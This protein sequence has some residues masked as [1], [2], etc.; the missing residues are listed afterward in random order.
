[1]PVSKKTSTAA[2]ARRNPPNADPASVKESGV[3]YAPAVTK[4]SVKLFPGV[5]QDVWPLPL[6]AADKMSLLRTGV[7]KNELERFKNLAGLDYDKL[8]GALAVTR[9]TLI[10]KKKEDYFNAALSERIIDLTDV[11][12]IGYEVFGDKEKFNSWVFRPIAALGG[13]YPFE[14]MD[15]QFGRAEIRDIIGRIATGVYS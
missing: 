9:A 7:S 11:Y 5:R 8:A 6:S 15:N 13:K 1:M 10:N 2:R 4:K 14:I 12:A 3:A